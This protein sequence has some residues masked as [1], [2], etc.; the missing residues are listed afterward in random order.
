MLDRPEVEVRHR[1][2]LSLFIL[3]GVIIQ[4]LD[5]T[6]ANVALPHMQASLGATPESISWVLTS[7]IIATAMVTPISGWLAMRYGMRT[8]F[9]MSVSVFVG[10]S[11]LCG[12]ATNLPQM[13]VFRIIQGIGGAS[14]GPLGQ[15][16][17]LNIYR[18]SDHPR[19]MSLF[20]IGLMVGPIVGP[21]LGGWLTDNFEWRWV[22]LVNLPVGLVCLAGLWWLMPQIKGSSRPFDLTGWALIA[23]ALAAF[24]LL[25]DRGGHVDWFDSAE[26]WVE[27]VMAGCAAWMFCI[28]TAMAPRPLFPLALLRD[29][30]LLIGAILMFMLGVLQMAALA[31]LPS[32]LQSLFGYPV[33][34]TGLVVATRGIG[35]IAA[36]WVGGRTLHVIGARIMMGSGMLLLSYS[37]WLMTGWSLE[38]DQGPILLNGIIQGVAIGFIFLPVSM[39]TFATLPSHFRTD[40]ASL[41]NL[42]RNV[43][44]SI[45]IA[46]ASAV[47]ARNV[48]VSHSDLAAHVT[49]YNL[50]LD[51]SLLNGY[52]D[53]GE[54]VMRMADGLITRQA[55]MIAFLDVY[56][57]ML[58]VSLCAL[59]I[60]FFVRE[61]RPAGG[62]EAVHLAMD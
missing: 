55:S 44:G 40:G 10:A 42:S 17:M 8:L 57:M 3:S 28:H 18:P 37:M 13:V 46:L 5:A 39:L 49:P 60:A 23:T 11:L 32:M 33:L 21:I 26:C 47:L 36:M 59:P 41:T 34:T 54:G 9:L 38:M 20:G 62:G 19:A 27:A 51:P 29:R 14:L 50:P 12:L 4:V 2:L 30:N 16:I 25:L 53:A 1:A 56:H 48:Q 15:S 45:G 61:R 6:I 58:I 22:F 24:Q 52:G 7:Y 43:G 35:M 31:L